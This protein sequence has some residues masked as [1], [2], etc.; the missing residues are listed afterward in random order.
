MP[1]A[2]YSGGGGSRR[3]G[4]YRALPVW[5]Q[6]LIP[7][8]A[9]AVVVIALVEFVNYETNNVPVLAGVSSASAVREQNREDTILVQQQQAP[10]VVRLKA[11]ESP[12]HGIRAA[13]IAYMVAISVSTCI[14]DL[15]SSLTGL[16]VVQAWTVGTLGL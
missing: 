7:F 8:A 2:N 15:S 6:W 9:A 13:V 4:G 11:G 1:V 16:F 5:A 10:Q 14:V 12:A 3:R